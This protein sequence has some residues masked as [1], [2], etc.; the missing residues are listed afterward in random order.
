MQQEQRLHS[1]T[2]LSVQAWGNRSIRQGPETTTTTELNWIKEKEE[3][4]LG[5][6]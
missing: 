5:I 2:C 4:G 1:K 3:K 6:G